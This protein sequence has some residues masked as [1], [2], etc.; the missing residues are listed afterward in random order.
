[1]ATHAFHS[2]S[3]RRGRGSHNIQVEAIHRYCRTC[4]MPVSV[5]WVRYNPLPHMR[6]LL[7]YLYSASGSRYYHSG[8]YRAPTPTSRPT[9]SLPDH[10]LL[11]YDDQI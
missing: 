10:S 11:V 5:S 7:R 1:M 8:G 4:Y 6:P 2:K 3:P 9:H